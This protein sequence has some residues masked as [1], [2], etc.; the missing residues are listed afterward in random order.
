MRVIPFFVISILAVL[1]C[2]DNGVKPPPD[3]GGEVE[4][5]VFIGSP[6]VIINEIHSANVDY[7][8]EFG[9]DPGWVEFY[10]PADT[11]VNL[12]GYHLT[13]SLNRKLWVFGDVAVAPRGYLTVFL[14]GRDRPNLEP[15][16]DSIDLI[17]SAVGAWTWA[18]N[19]NTPAGRSTAEYSF[20]RNTSIGGTL[21]T[22]DNA[23]ALD[24]SSAVVMLVLNDWDETDVVDISG[25]DQI[26]FRGRV[27]KNVRLE[28]RLPHIDVNDWEAWPAIIRGTGNDDDLYTIE[29]PSN[30]AGFPDLKNIY[31]IRFANPP[32]DRGTINFSFNSII[33]RKRGGGV[34]ASFELS[35]SGGKLFLMDSS[36]RIRDSAA[37]PAEVT[38]LSFA[39]NFE[40]G[41]WALSKPPTP[42][43]AN[44]SESYDGQ[45]RPPASASVPASGY[46]Q[47]ALTFTL[48]QP[49]DEVTLCCDTSGRLPTAESAL[50]SGVTL[51]L[52]KTTVIRCAQFKDG[53]YPSDAIMRTYIIGER[54]PDLPLVS[55]AVDPYDMFDSDD[56]LYAA[57]PN[58]SPSEPHYGA[59]YWRDDE[60]PVQVDFFES[61]AK[62]AWS[63]GAGLR[64]SGNWSRANAKKSV[65]ITFRE[66]YGQKNLKYGL[67]PD[68]P[69]L[70]KFKHFILRNNGNNFPQD[71]IRDMLMTSLTE[72]LG[73][74]YQKGR[75]T[76]VYYNGQYFGIH[77]LRERSNGDYFDTNYGVDEEFI[78]L[79][80]M[81]GEV[82]RGSDADYQDIV[83]W[84]ESVTLDDNNMK[85]LEQRIDVDNFTNHF[86]CRI[87][88]NDRDWPGNNMKRW[89]V[90]SPPSKWRWLMYDTDH[91]FGSYGIYQ[92]PNIGMLTLATAANGPS[93]P[94]PPHSTLILRKLLENE[95]Y[96]SAFINRFSLLLAAYFTPA[97]IGARIDALMAPI[98]SEIPLDQ[99]RWKHNAGTMS[100]Q[101]GVIRD[102]G[103]TRGAQMQREIGEFFKLDG[104][105][106]FT[107]SVNGNGKIF[108]HDLLIPNESVTFKAYPA[109]PVT[110]KAVPNPGMMFEGW[111][112][113][114]SDTERTVMVGETTTLEARFGAARF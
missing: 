6:P 39:K 83:R 103:N 37:Y 40:S 38:G 34:H 8:D 61:G 101:L 112:D 19:Q 99:A 107:V 21:T 81:G 32:S 1:S 77:N 62:L 17:R 102:F 4:R 2:V 59:N 66:D 105:A 67:F 58:A 93:W 111:S 64:I 23:P 5:P 87:F 89:R 26:L 51:D 68:Y 55:I 44:S 31:G 53:A 113:G 110:L 65:V 84:L 91:G 28:I 24:W 33:A 25:A 60:L 36:W 41:A 30:N 12:S 56:G 29:L 42:N 95:S 86:Q 80:K 63:S 48:P 50:K 7:L 97:R 10:N 27:D 11:A 88:Y 82:S 22:K 70:T 92:Q 14:S 69:N 114:V 71:Y 9:D 108:I 72:G 52:T 20:V 90:N 43:A 76:I 15:P 46:F 16:R 104:A 78:D 54:L 106:D 49:G 75:A 100:S 57:G 45:I 18:D 109:V 96:K 85:I 94:N 35:R 73:I 3:G 74:D 79:I 47:N 98:E 13:N